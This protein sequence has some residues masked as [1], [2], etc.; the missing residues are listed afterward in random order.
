MADHPYR[1]AKFLLSARAAAHFP[2]DTGREIAFAGR[3]NVGKSSVINTITDQKGLARTSKTPGRT[4]LINFFS[5]NDDTRLVDLPGY[6]YARV[7]Q[8]MRDE[9]VTLING[10]LRRRRSLAGLVM[11][12]DVRRELSAA[13]STMLD[14]CAAGGIPAHLLIN[15]ADKLPPGRRR[16]TLRGLQRRLQDQATVQLYSTLDKTG[17]D[18]L[19]AV[20]DGWL[21][22]EKSGPRH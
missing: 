17:A 9:W 10:Y 11:I 19:R 20:L 6:G 12:I 8:A 1:R 2:A 14:W 18:E 5:I 16:E 3:S 15:K 21:Y 4:Q 22:S 7:P 13:D